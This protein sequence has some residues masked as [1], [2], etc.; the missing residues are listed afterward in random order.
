MLEERLL[1]EVK[2]NYAAEIKDIENLKLRF[3]DASMASFEVMWRDI[4]DSERIN[5]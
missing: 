5:S 2:D 4:K 1:S 3:G